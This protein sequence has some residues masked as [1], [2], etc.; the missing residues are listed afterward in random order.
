MTAWTPTTLVGIDDAYDR[1]RASDGHSRLGAYLADRPGRFHEYGEPDTPLT[2]AE[3]AAAVWEVA[4]SPVMS[5]GYVHTRPDLGAVRLAFAEDGSGLVARVTVTL[6]HSA[7]RTRLPYAWRDW[8]P[9]RYGL[10]DEGPYRQLVAPGDDRPAVLVT[11][12]VSAPLAGCSLHTPTATRSHGL[13]ADAK[14]ALRLLV[15]H[16]N[17]HAGPMVATVHGQ[18]MTA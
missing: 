7:L 2:A 4:T 14:Q 12:E 11:A 18:P 1:A 15:A 3:F 16:V 5:P 13:V 9:D 8:G 10:A 17:A 6:P